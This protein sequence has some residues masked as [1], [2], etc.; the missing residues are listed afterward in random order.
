VKNTYMVPPAHPPPYPVCHVRTRVACGAC[1]L[2]AVR[3][4]RS[5]LL[6]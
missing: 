5:Q 1:R 3:V 2:C 6:P 4:V